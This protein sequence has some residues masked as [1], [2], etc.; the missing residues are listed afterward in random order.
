MTIF[1]VPWHELELD[2]VWQFLVDAGPEPLYWEAKGRELSRAEVRLQVCGFANSHEG[3]FLILGASETNAG[4]DLSG[5]SFPTDP[6][7]WVSEVVGNGSVSPYPDGLD[8]RAFRV[9]DDRWIAVTRIPPV[10]TPPC[11]TA[12]RVYERV[13]GRTIPVTEPLRLASLFERGDQARARAEIGANGAAVEALRRGLSRPNHAD[14]HIQFGLALAAAGYRPNISARLFS[15]R[16]EEDVISIIT[17]GLAR[18]SFGHPDGPVVYRDVSQDSRLFETNPQH[19]MGDAWSV[20]I[21]WDGVV[22]INWVQAV[23]HTRVETVVEGPVR[24]AWAAADEM[25][26][27]VGARGGRHLRLTVA[28]AMFPPNP[29]DQPQWR[30]DLPTLPMVSRGPLRPRTSEM[31]LSSIARELN[32][33]IGSMEYEP[34]PDR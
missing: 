6:P 31:V 20:K 9:A 4:W 12:G 27:G 5:L 8:T 24:R 7:T 28:G 19:R 10:A 11:N 16:Y 18:D 13:S 21:T 30:A 14:T 33:S 3:G 34:P 29:S 17:T 26:D 23:T 22:G 15:Q 32:R 2:H 1:G 25:L